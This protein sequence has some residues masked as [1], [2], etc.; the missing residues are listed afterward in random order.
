MI[1]GR[2][3]WD[4]KSPGGV[5][6]KY[7]QT[8]LASELGHDSVRDVFVYTQGSSSVYPPRSGQLPGKAL[9]VASAQ[10]LDLST[11]NKSNTSK[12]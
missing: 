10:P 12:R 9:E 4:L 11:Q 6:P 1:Q 5:G 8:F 2:N 7:D 3:H